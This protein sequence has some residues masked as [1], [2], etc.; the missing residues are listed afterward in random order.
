[1][2]AVEQVTILAEQG[3]AALGF[4]VSL[5]GAVLAVFRA[6]HHAIH[7]SLSERLNHFLAPGLRQLAGKKSAVPNDDA[8]RHFLFRELLVRHKNPSSSMNGLRLPCHARAL[9]R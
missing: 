7:A 6:E 8:H 5:N 9:T 4:V 3:G 1:D 2:H